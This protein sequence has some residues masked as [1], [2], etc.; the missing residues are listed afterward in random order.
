LKKPRSLKNILHGKGRVAFLG[1][2]GRVGTRNDSV[3]GDLEGKKRRN[4][5][6][7]LLDSVWGHF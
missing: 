3:R 6:G 5:G 1:E 4:G 7:E 2:K